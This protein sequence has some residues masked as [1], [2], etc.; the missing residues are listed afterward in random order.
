MILISICLIGFGHPDVIPADSASLLEGSWSLTANGTPG[1][2]VI[3]AYKDGKIEGTMFG[4]SMSGA[5]DPKTKQVVLKRLAHRE[6]GEPSVVQVFTGAFAR[7]SEFKPALY[8]F[9]GTFKSVAGKDW[10]KPDTEYEWA[11][12]T[13]PP[14]RAKSLRELQG[15]WR[16][17]S[18]V[19]G[20]GPP[21]L[22]AK[23]GLIEKSSTLVICG[24]EVRSDGELVGTLADDLHTPDQVNQPPTRRLLMLTLP[25]GSAWLC[26]YRIQNDVLQIVYPHGVINVGGHQVGLK[27][28]RK[29][30]DARSK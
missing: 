24:N 30:E 10:G 21:K 7:D 27:R 11:A 28:V 23:T 18:S 17:A 12:T 2:L 26:A 19:W 25:D 16:V 14:T 6:G 15:Q 8:S 4:D 9:K 20:V 29:S 22:P 13:G 1:A 3:K 5:Y